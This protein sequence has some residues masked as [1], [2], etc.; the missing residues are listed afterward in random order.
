MIWSGHPVSE[1]P[2]IGGVNADGSDASNELTKLILDVEKEIGLPRPD[3]AV[4]YHPGI[5]RDVLMKSAKALP[6]AMKPK[7]FNF[8]IV[9]NHLLAKGATEEEIRCGAVVIGCV[10]AGVEGKVW[11]NNQMGLV[12]LGKV[13]EL[14]LNNGVDM[15]SGCQIGPC[16]G[17]AEKFDSFPALMAAFSQQLDHAI[18]LAVIQAIAIEEVH[19]ELNPQPLC[20]VM[21]QDCLERGVPV[22]E[23]GARYAIPGLVGVGLASVA[24]S[25]EVVRRLVFHENIIGMEELMQAL[26]TNWAGAEILRRRCVHGAS[27][28]GNDDDAVDSLAAEIAELYCSKMASYR[29]PRGVPYY[30]GLYSVSAHVALGQSVSA[31]PDGRFALSPLADGM[32]PSQGVVEKG[33]TAVLKSMTK[34]EQSQITTGTLQ[35]MKITQSSLVKHEDKFIDLVRTYMELGGYHAQFNIHD[36]ATLIAAQKDPDKYAGLVVRVAAYAAEFTS[37]PKAMQ[38][39]IIKRSELGLD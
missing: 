24:D 2:T 19:R 36:T 17:E 33:P 14:A 10:T 35:N 37:L 22:W 23:G 3:I 18:R 32:S 25:L 12:N 27:K 26:R 8:E 38:D 34:I 6:V 9:R 5:D 28:Y 21:T 7:F 31:T 13:L 15:L 30:P 29:S 11:G 16:T 4:M 1:Q 39:D 20:S